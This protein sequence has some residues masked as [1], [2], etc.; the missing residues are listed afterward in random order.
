MMS[1]EC[2]GVPIYFLRPDWVA[3]QTNVFYKQSL[4]LV[5]ANNIDC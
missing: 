5:Y 4:K 1:G 2:L 3:A